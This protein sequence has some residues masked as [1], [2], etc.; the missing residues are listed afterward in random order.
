MTTLEPYDEVALADIDLSDPEFW[1]AP[2]SFRDGAFKTLRDTP[3]L[4][5]F[6][7]REIPTSPSR[8][9][10]ATGR[11]TRHD[12]VW[13]PA[14]T[15]SCSARGKGATS[16]TCPEFNEF[17][18]SMINMDD[19]RTRGCAD[20]VAGLHAEGLTASRTSCSTGRRGH[21]PPDRTPDKTCDF[22]E[23]IAAPLPLEII[24]DMMGIPEDYGQVFD[25]T[26]IILGVGDPEFTR[27]FEDLMGQALEMFMY[28]QALGE[29]R[30]ANP[31]TTS[32]RSVDAEV[33][34]ER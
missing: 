34:G 31:R 22:V 5:H 27:S 17:F 32:P 21:R 30:K 23:D 1:L 9:A 19:P 24:C 14:A 29:D 13:T 2:R 8:P 20:R 4:V 18:G 11:V 10:R 15:R 26:N 12:D 6:A 3:G 16:A 7:E 28:A 25:W 33:D